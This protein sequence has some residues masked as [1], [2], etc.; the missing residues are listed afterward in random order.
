METPLS[1][2]LDPANLPPGTTVGPWRVVSRSA[3]GTYGTVYRAVSSEQEE[4]VPVALKLAL[5]PEDPRFS[6]E[7]AVLARLD[8][9]SVPLVLDHGRWRDSSGVPYPYITMAWIEGTP[10]YDWAR[11]HNPTSLQVIQLLAH[12]ARALEATHK[13]GAVHRD[14]KGD[15]VLVR[16]EDTRAVL[17]DFGSSNHRG[18]FRL[19]WRTQ[20]PG[21]PAYRSPEAWSFG[22]DSDAHYLATPADDVFALGVTAYRLVTGQYP[23]STE[24]GQPEAHVWQPEGSGPTPPHALNS[25]VDPRLSALILRML[26][27]DPKARGTARALAEA[28]EFAAT[29][30]VPEAQ[31]PLFEQVPAPPPATETATGKRASVKRTEPHAISLIW[32]PWLTFATFGMVLAFWAGQAMSTRV[33][34]IRSTAQ[35]A[36]PTE[37]PDAGTAAVGDSPPPPTP[38]PSQQPASKEPVASEYQRQAEPDARG[39]CPD[40]RHVARNERCWVEQP[41]NAEQCERS[42]YVYEQGK[43]YAPVFATRRKPTSSPPEPQ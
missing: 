42:G 41:M 1:P 5:H 20:P 14:V 18:A 34:R 32:L 7:A 21:T 8:H 17:T 27:A 19:T 3:Q 12:L 36:P 2:E 35:R 28:L 33:E 29:Q 38:D 31:Q 25:R 10:L 30:P 9:P 22:L 37:Q 13:A 40:A 11:E 6:R 26:S 24:P 39:R 15:N 4:P 43:C 23:P 16:H